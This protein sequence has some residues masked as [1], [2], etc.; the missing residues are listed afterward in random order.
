MK[1]PH[2]VASPHACW[3]SGC[4]AGVIPKTA[5]DHNPR[6]TTIAAG[7]IG[8]RWLYSN[9]VPES[10]PAPRTKDKPRIDS[11]PGAM[12]SPNTGSRTRYTPRYCY[13]TYLRYACRVQVTPLAPELWDALTKKDIDTHW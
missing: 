13:L 10:S 6:I 5:I 1:C 12:P 11:E 4:T 9:A 2:G 7:P 8:S 3:C